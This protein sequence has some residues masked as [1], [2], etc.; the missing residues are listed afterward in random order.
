MPA[1]RGEV[2]T[3]SP[4]SSSVGFVRSGRVYSTQLALPFSREPRVGTACVKC[5]EPYRQDGASVTCACGTS[6]SGY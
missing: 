2:R 3:T 1:C 4:R 5:G 6:V